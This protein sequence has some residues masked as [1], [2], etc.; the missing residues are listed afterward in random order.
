MEMYS[1]RGQ[2]ELNDGHTIMNKDRLCMIQGFYSYISCN[3]GGH[4]MYFSKPERETEFKNL[5]SHFSVYDSVSQTTIYTI[6]TYICQY[7]HD[8]SFLYFVP[9]KY[10]VN[11]FLLQDCHKP[12]QSNVF[13]I[14]GD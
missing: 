12:C 5:R 9:Q 13:L 3:I 1:N 10:P 4:Y 2:L 7:I 8:I 6:Y 14:N 11:T